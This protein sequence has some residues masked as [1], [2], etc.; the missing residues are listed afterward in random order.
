MAVYHN[1]KVKDIIGCETPL[2]KSCCFRPL[3]KDC[4]L[5][6]RMAGKVVRSFENMSFFYVIKTEDTYYLTNDV[7][8]MD[9]VDK[10][11]T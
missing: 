4:V 1:D 7:V 6:G 11:R 5:F 8:E 2:G 10:E 3:G 9:F